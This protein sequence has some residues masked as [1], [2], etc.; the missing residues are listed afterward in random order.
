MHVCKLGY[1]YSLQARDF[2]GNQSEF[3]HPVFGK[4]YD[5]GVRP[6]VENLRIEEQEGILSLNWEYDHGFEG[7]L[8]A[9]YKT[10]ANGSLVYHR[11]TNEM[12]FR[13]RLPQQTISYAIKVFTA[14][15]GESLLS[16]EVVY[17]VE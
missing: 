3:A 14:D 15:G 1:Y 4:A 7:I 2:S 11:R 9:I 13:E 10:N 6:T 5:D 8:F 16:D 12:E 17:V